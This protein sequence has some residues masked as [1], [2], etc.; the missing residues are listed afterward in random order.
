MFNLATTRVTTSNNSSYCG[1]RVGEKPV[2]ST[3]S[4]SEG[5][6]WNTGPALWGEETA[7][8]ASE[9][10]ER[11]VDLAG[12]DRDRGLAVSN[13]SAKS[14][15][16][17]HECSHRS[18]SAEAGPAPWGALAKTPSSKRALRERSVWIGSR[19]QCGQPASAQT[20]CIPA[21]DEA[22]AGSYTLSVLWTTL[23]PLRFKGCLWHVCINLSLPA[24]LRT[25]FLIS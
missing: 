4:S 5:D 23:A 20:V 2:L 19:S 12:E 13:P 15:C 9:P 22:R 18:A 8:R 17:P 3:S 11:A 7:A 6:R 21:R 1:D 14:N 16:E 25:N 24:F 10:R